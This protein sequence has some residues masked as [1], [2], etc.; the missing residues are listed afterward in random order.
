MRRNVGVW[1]DKDCEGVAL[2][3]LCGC[4]MKGTVVVGH[5]EDC[6]DVA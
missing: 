6:G 2:G 3:G 1:L 4:G 5:E